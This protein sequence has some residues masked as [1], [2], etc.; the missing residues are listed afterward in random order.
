MSNTL[1]ASFTPNTGVLSIVVNFSGI[2][3]SNVIISSDPNNPNDHILVSSGDGGFTTINGGASASLSI[4]APILQISFSALNNGCIVHLKNLILPL[5]GQAV[6]VFTINNGSGLGFVEVEPGT[7]MPS[8]T[9]NLISHPV[10]FT[11]HPG[12]QIGVLGNPTPV[13]QPN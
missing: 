6:P 11:I 2:P 7:V 5:P 1:S 8:L 12:A 9:I 3:P 10:N 4:T 13:A